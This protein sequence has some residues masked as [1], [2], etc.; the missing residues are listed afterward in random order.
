MKK[1]KKRR[2]NDNVKKKTTTIS[3]ADSHVLA[4]NTYEPW[5]KRRKQILTTLA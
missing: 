3:Q 5:S 1:K 4:L 2:T